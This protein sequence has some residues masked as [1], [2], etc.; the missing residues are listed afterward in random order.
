MICWISYPVKNVIGTLNTRTRVFKSNCRKNGYKFSLGLKSL[1][2]MDCLYIRSKKGFN[3]VHLSS[4]LYVEQTAMGVLIVT[5]KK[6]YALTITLEKMEWLLPNTC[7]SRAHDSFLVNLE[8]VIGFDEEK[9]FIDQREI[10]L[11]EKYK[12]AFIKRLNII[13]EQDLEG[14]VETSGFSLN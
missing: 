6:T 7:F 12:A 2:L 13:V 3:K 9:V 14:Y 5:A 4:I 1:A 10:P 8:C 11:N